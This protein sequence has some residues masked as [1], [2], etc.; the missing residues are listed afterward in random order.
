MKILNNY[1]YIIGV[2]GTFNLSLPDG[3]IS[4]NSGVSN[5]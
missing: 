4:L 3:I 5:P 1:F 2:L